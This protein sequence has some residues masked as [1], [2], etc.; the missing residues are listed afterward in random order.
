MALCEDNALY[1]RTLATGK[2]LHT[3]KGHKSKVTRKEILLAKSLIF[4]IIVFP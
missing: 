3:L 2:E 4:K 1:V